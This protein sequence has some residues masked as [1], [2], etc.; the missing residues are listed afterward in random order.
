LEPEKIGRWWKKNEEIDIVATKENDL[1]V[2]EVKWS[3]KP[4]DNKVLQKLQRK[5]GLLLEDLNKN[6]DNITYCLFSK[7]GFD[8]LSPQKN[9]LMV[10]LDDIEKQTKKHY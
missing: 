5:T 3:N 9:L 10:S 2:C 6:F 7:S 1:Y 8:G 4:I